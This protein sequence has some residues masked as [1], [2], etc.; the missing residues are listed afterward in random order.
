VAPLTAWKF[1]SPVGADAVPLKL[2]DLEDQH[3]TQIHD[4][5]VVGRP[6]GRDGIEHE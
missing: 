2:D 1:P 3:L 5:A 4:Y 6:E